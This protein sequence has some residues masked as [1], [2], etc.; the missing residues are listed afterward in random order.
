MLARRA[1]RAKVESEEK[2][3]LMLRAGAVVA[4]LVVALVIWLI[5]RSPEETEAA[6][7]TTAEEP[8]ASAE[9]TSQSKPAGKSKGKPKW[10]K[11]KRSDD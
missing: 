10:R 1:D 9:P 6:S 3:K 8:A 4:A 11:P 7:E 2:R 5:A